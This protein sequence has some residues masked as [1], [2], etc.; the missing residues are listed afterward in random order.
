MS[1]K[2]VKAYLIAFKDGRNG[3]RYLCDHHYKI[4]R[5]VAVKYIT[6]IHSDVYNKKC[7]IC[8]VKR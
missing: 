5:K 6:L 1:K 3:L 4:A 2:T 8:K 7:H